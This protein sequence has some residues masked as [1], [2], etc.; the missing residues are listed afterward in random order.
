MRLL[1]GLGN[2]G[3]DYERNRHN[4]GFMTIDAIAENYK[5][6]EPRKK[7]LGQIFEGRFD[8]SRI[9]LLKPSTF[10]NR[11]GLSVRAAVDFYKMAPERIFVFCDDID[12]A[13]GKV[14]VKLGGGH[15]GHKGLRDICAHIGPDFYRIRIGVGHPGDKDLVTPHVLA[16]FTKAEEEWVRPLLEAIAMALPRL[17]HE[18]P[19][20]FTNE[21]ARLRKEVGGGQGPGS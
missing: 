20:Q 7:F 2:P 16:D 18:G 8:D 1:V 3:K 10:M 21:L 15:A 11:S 17:L 5:F 6:S 14:K 13:P 9:L 19:S 12:L 4:I